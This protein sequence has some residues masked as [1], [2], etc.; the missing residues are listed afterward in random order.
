MSPRIWLGIDK[1][2]REP[3]CLRFRPNGGA[4]GPTNIREDVTVDKGRSSYSGA[5]S[6][7]QFDLVGNALIH[8]TRE[9]SA[10]LRATNVNPR[11][12]RN[13]GNL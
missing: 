11:V 6:T 1:F 2:I 8:I 3:L 10:A 7:D 9:I 13:S 12:S 5:F 4:S